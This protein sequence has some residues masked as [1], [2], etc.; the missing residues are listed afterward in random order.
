MNNTIIEVAPVSFLNHKNNPLTPEEIAD[1]VYRCYKEG[2][3]IFHLHVRDEMGKECKEA[4]GFLKTIR[5]I[6]EKCD[7]LIN[8]NATNFQMLSSYFDEYPEMKI[9]PLHL[10][11]LTLF[12]FALPFTWDQI[13]HNAKN[14]SEYDLVQEMC[15]FDLA[16]IH[17]AKKIIKDGNVKNPYLYTFYLN[18]P[19][20]LP[21]SE[22]N[23]TILSE[24]MGADDIWFYA[25]CNRS[26][27]DNIKT[28]LRLGGNIRVGFED[29]FYDDETQYPTNHLL[30]R[31]VAELSKQYNRGIADIEETKKRLGIKL[32]GESI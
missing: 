17:N 25:E 29:S 13:V 7:I 10:G 5:L 9:C 21:A 12:N 11:S 8:I 23:I 3:T 20:Q 32:H 1:E 2:A 19:G 24:E 16:N 14:N 18:Y 27:Y 6:R 26:N 4:E 30:V 15:I 31:K 28:A 22:K